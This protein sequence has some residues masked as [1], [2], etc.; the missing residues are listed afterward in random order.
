MNFEILS[1]NA[2]FLLTYFQVEILN[3]NMLFPFTFLK[4]W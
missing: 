2:P 4:V 3:K 1:K